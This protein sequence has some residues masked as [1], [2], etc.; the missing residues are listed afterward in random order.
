MTVTD[1]VVA[2]ARLLVIVSLIQ[3]ARRAWVR[4]HVEP[5][6]SQLG[7]AAATLVLIVYLVGGVLLA[8]WY[9]VFVYP[10][11]LPLFVVLAPVY[12]VGGW[13]LVGITGVWVERRYV[14]SR[15][16]RQG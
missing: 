16:S 3:G 9:F 12:I 15:A 14:R 11:F 4:R 6:G 10:R 8:T 13:K 7:T 2:A 1:W 5:P